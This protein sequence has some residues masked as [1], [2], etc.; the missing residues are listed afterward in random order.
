MRSL[1]ASP[2]QVREN[3]VNF[4]NDEKNDY[5][6]VLN[7]NFV[8]LYCLNSWFDVKVNTKNE[9][10]DFEL[11]RLRTQF[12]IKI[13][14]MLVRLRFPNFIVINSLY[15]LDLIQDY[16]KNFENS[17]LPE[18]EAYP[19]Y[20]KTKEDNLFLNYVVC[21]MVANK[22]A[23]D[24]AMKAK[25]W[26]RL[27]KIPI[28]KINELELVLLNVILKH[29]PLTLNFNISKLVKFNNNLQSKITP[30]NN[31]IED[32]NAKFNSVYGSGATTT[33]ATPEKVSLPT[34]QPSPK[35]IYQA[36]DSPSEPN[37]SSSTSSEVSPSS[38]YTEEQSSVSSYSPNSTTTSVYSVSNDSGIKIQNIPQNVTSSLE[39]FI[40]T[41]TTNFKKPET[42]V[43][44][45]SNYYAASLSNPYKYIDFEGKVNE[46]KV[47]QEEEIPEYREQYYSLEVYEC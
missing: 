40:Q 13:K 26:S 42:V 2:D 28:R 46:K 21:L 31:Y 24:F 34:P 9:L 19:S 7:G 35:P 4:I 47:S 10:Q 14:K 23:N 16:T 11:T 15:F 8:G 32:F 38:S 18:D 43:T 39:K 3:I 25:Y 20:Y 33:S 44:T 1:T 29:Q 41:P 37:S 22:S 36:K 12:L 30:F 5:N 6:R 27:T 17:N 45:N